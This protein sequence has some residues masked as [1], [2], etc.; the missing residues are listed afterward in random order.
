VIIRPAK[1]VRGRLLLP[2]D[3]SI[4]HRAAMIAALAAGASRIE[5]FSTSADC[6]S[7]LSCLRRLG[8]RIERD[9]ATVVVQGTGRAGLQAPREPLDC[10]NS[11]TT[12]RLLAGILAGQP[13]TSTLTGDES[14]RSRPMRRII[15]PLELM[16]SRVSSVDGRAPISIDG[17]GP[18]KAIS[19]ALPVPSAQ[20]KSCV[21]LAGLN[22]QGKTEVVESAGREALA[23]ASG[24][25]SYSEG[26]P[27]FAHGG[28]RDHTERMLRWFGL[29]VDIRDEDRNGSHTQVAAVNGPAH[30]K[31]RDVS[32]PGDVSSAAFFVAAAALLPGSTLE[33]PRIGVNPTRDLFLKL[34]ASLGADVTVNKVREECNEPVG[35][36]QV[37]GGISKRRSGGAAAAAESRQHRQP[38]LIRGALIPQLIDELPLL[39]VVGTQI[40]GG[41]EIRDAAELRVK[42]SDRIAATVE[43]LRA[44]GADVEEFDDGLRVSGPVR[45]R[46]GRINPRGDHR[47]AMAFTIAGLVAEGETEIQNAECAAVSFPE[48]FDLLESVVER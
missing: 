22:A 38:C 18:L 44:M 25:P 7:T 40:A 1:L 46:G 5:G 32:V 28:P 6:A 17:R 30:L 37:V 29:P 3:K 15:E 41:I 39:A 24:L 11:G 16:G 21:L 8:I 2:G 13:F 33:L 36:V 34:I 48:F 9:G 27:P 19:Y 10:G 14:L 42:E 12:M 23:V 31:A 47:I 43:N 35:T 26:V 20:V 4:S 45:L